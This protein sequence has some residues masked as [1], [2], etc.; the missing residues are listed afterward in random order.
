MTLGW[1]VIGWLW[2]NIIPWFIVV[3]G[4]M[5]LLLMTGVIIMF[6]HDVWDEYGRK[7]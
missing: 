6:V 2:Q 5:F 4:G 7:K 3:V 1:D